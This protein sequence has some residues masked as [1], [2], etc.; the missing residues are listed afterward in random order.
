MVF[1]A[2]IGK[3]GFAPAL[4]GNTDKR[5][6]VGNNVKIVVFTLV[7]ALGFGVQRIRTKME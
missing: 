7:V 5:R 1:D 3:H 4:A 6:I 2:V